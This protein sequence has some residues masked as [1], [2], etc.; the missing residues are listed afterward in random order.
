[1]HVFDDGR[2]VR[3]VESF[4]DIRNFGPVQRS[5][6]EE[7]G[8]VSNYLVNRKTALSGIVMQSKNFK[9]SKI[10]L[11]IHA[12]KTFA[13]VQTLTGRFQFLE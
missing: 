13:K 9:L 3:R 4:G 1:M 6:L 5:K 8:Y 2:F 7:P 12:S 10:L 11:Q